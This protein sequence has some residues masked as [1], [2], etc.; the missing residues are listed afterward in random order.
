MPSV[1]PLEDFIIEY[2]ECQSQYSMIKVMPGRFKEY[3]FRLQEKDNKNCLGPYI[4]FR[5][6]SRR[7]PRARAYFCNVARDGECLP[8][9]DSRRATADCVVPMRFANSSWVT[10]AAARAFKNSSSKSNSSARR[11][12]S[13]LISGLSSAFFFSWQH[14]G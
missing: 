9:P 8:F 5:C 3:S 12:Y 10:P 7:Q 6:T 13:A 1:G 2:W 4:L 14:T 11:S